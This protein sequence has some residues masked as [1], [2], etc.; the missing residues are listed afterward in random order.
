MKRRITLIVITVVLV[1]SAALLENMI[2]YWVDRFSFLHEN[3]DHIATEQ[4]SVP[5]TIG[6]DASLIHFMSPV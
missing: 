6:W 4:Q 1:I 5:P 2:L 3:S